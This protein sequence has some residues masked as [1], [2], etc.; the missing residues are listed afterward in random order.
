MSLAKNYNLMDFRA[1]AKRRLPA[2]LFHYIDG[3][4]DDEWSLI[5]NTKAFERYQLLPNYLRDIS[6]VDLST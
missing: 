3:G 1:G 4:A 6:K 5:N 2:P